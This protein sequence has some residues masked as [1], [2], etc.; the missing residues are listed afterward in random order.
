MEDIHTF[1]VLAYKESEF[2]EECIKSVCNQSLKTK[3]LIATSTPN[4]YINNLAKKYNLK[5]LINEGEKGIGNDFNFAIKCADTELV[6][7]AHQDDI[8]DYNYA[9]E[10]IENYQK[11]NKSLI[12]FTDYYEIRNFEKVYKNTNL[13]IKRILLRPLLNKNKSNKTKNKR[14]VLKY[15]N[16]ICCPAV[17]F[18]KKNIKKGIIDKLFKCNFVC[19]V[20]WYTWELLSKEEGNFIYIDKPLMG[21]RIS[22]ESTTSKIIS[23]NIRTKE[24]LIMYK[25]FWPTFIAKIFNSFYVKSEKSNNLNNENN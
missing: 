14:K 3:V 10:I 6:T 24:D 1:V 20:D 19:N 8:Y 22:E 16:S 7:I 9:K 23:E 21:H 13:N 4:E 25:K 12:L 2:L 15:G 18:S 11:Y 5:V 17:T